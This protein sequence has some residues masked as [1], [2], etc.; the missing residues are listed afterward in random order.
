[1]GER[2][3]TRA[4]QYPESGGGATYCLLSVVSPAM[5]PSYGRRWP[6]APARSRARRRGKSS[7]GGPEVHQK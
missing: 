3:R 5:M 6:M 1:V 4:F 2:V 7:P